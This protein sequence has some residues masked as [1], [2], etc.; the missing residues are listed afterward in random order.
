[1]TCFAGSPSTN[2]PARCPPCSPELTRSPL[3]GRSFWQGE[4]DFGIGD[5][6]HRRNAGTC[7]RA[8]ADTSHANAHTN[9]NTNPESSRAGAVANDSGYGVHT[10]AR[11]W[12]RCLCQTGLLC[13]VDFC[14]WA[15]SDYSRRGADRR[16]G[17]HA[18][19]RTRRP[20]VAIGNRLCGV[21]A[22]PGRSARFGDRRPRR[23]SRLRT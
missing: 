5:R 10:T 7:A 19:R 8:D 14:T 6:G 2:A 3:G 9:T 22:T 17:A 16:R 20:P 21:P 12:I 1:V 18:A 13:R 23:R 15:G 11:P 4:R